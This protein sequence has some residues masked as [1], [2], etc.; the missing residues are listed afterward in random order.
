M[1]ALPTGQRPLR[2]FGMRA[3]PEDYA[4]DGQSGSAT[5]RMAEAVAPPGP[6][7]ESPA[8]LSKTKKE[9]PTAKRSRTPSSASG[10]C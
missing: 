10:S 7:E 6:S 8:V 4:G 2:L 5:P 1:S 9:V 3:K